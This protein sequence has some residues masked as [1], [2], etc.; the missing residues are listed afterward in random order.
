MRQRQHPIPPFRPCSKF[1]GPQKQAA[2][3]IIMIAILAVSHLLCPPAWRPIDAPPR[4]P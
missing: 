4:H 2:M 3:P 1:F